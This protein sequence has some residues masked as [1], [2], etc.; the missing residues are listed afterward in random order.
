MEQFK[1]MEEFRI[2]TVEVQAVTED[3]REEISNV[4]LSFNSRHQN[5]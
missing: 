1:L 4:V 3:V 5:V 2:C